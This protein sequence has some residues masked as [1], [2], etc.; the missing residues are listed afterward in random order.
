MQRLLFLF[1]Y[2]DFPFALVLI[3]FILCTMHTQQPSLKANTYHMKMW[4]VFNKCLLCQIEQPQSFTLTT[5][6]IINPSI[7]CR[8][9]LRTRHTIHFKKEEKSPAFQS[10]CGESVWKAKFQLSSIQSFKSHQ[11]VSTIFQVPLPAI[12]HFDFLR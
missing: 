3:I 9:V 5:A 2:T 10:G 4:Y 12:R 1:F 7:T 8:S 6:I 11:P